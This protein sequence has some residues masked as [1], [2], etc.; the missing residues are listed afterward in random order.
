MKTSVKRE[1]LL[2]IAATLFNRHGF[3]ATGI[4]TILKEA[5]IAK[6]TL[7]RHFKTKDALVIAALRRIDEDFRANM[8]TYVDAQRVTPTKKLLATFDYLGEW[9]NNPDFHGCPFVGAAGEYKDERHPVF[10]EATTH[11]RLMMA[12]FEELAH[13]AKLSNPKKVAEQINLLHEGA[14]A[15]AFVTNDS[16]EAQTAKSTAAELI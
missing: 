10:R 16:S 9:F 8:R 13:A 2:N 6:T 14:I 11:K 5:G 4:D 15:L 1:E 3:Q 7:Y 12:Y